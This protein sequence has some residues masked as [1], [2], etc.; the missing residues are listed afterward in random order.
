MDDDDSNDGVVD[1]EVRSGDETR[2]PGGGREGGKKEGPGRRG[3]CLRE[4]SPLVDGT[5]TGRETET[6]TESAEGEAGGKGKEEGTNVGAVEE[7]EGPEGGR[8][9][10]KSESNESAETGTEE[11]KAGRGVTEADGESGKDRC[12][13]VAG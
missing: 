7:G 9:E 10:I 6:G 3:G 2:T 1:G 12:E 11:E 13:G 4:R 8:D 5:L